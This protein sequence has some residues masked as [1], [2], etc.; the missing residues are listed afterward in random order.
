MLA[1]VVCCYTVLTKQ[2]NVF[3]SN[4]LVNQSQLVFVMFKYTEL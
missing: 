2:Q 1:V 4:P 3:K